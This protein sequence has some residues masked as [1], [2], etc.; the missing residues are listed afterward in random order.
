MS[1]SKTSKKRYRDF[2]EKFRSG[3]LKSKE[4]DRLEKPDEPDKQVDPQEKA[5]RKAKRR[6]YL[7]HYIRRLWP[8][9][10]MVVLLAV[11]AI[12]VSTLEIIQPLFVRYIFD[13]VLLAE[14]NSIDRLWHLNLVGL[15]FLGLVILT[16]TIGIIRSWNQ[17]LFEPTGHLDAAAGFV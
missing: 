16:R 8:H 13:D 4:D 3:K 15:I 10:K 12:T 17:R 1:N 7:N 14:S 9:W 11:L 6:S 2:L 5:E